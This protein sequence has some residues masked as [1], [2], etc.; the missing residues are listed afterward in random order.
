MLC[1]SGAHG[2]QRKIAKQTL[3]DAMQRLRRRWR[4]VVSGVRPIFKVLRAAGAVAREFTP[5]L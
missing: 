3:I 5:S 2:P 1:L 4:C